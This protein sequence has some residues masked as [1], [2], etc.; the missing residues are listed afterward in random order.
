VGSAAE[1]VATI[2]QRLGP[3]ARVLSVRAEPRPGLG[4]WLRAPRFVVVA[5]LPALPRTPNRTESLVVPTSPTECPP[6]EPRLAVML[7]RAGFSD[8][9][10]GRLQALPGWRSATEQPLQQ[11]LVQMGREIHTTVGIRPPRP[12]PSRAAFFGPSGAGCTTALCKWLSR[13]VFT[14]STTGQVWKVEFD[15][16]NPAPALGV[17]CE[18]LSIPLE[19]YTPGSPVMDRGF[20]LV[21]LP[22]L[23]PPGT[24]AAAALASFFEREQITGRV[25]VLNAA[26]DAGS[27]RAACAR[28]REFGA[29]HLVLSHMDEVPHWGRLWEFLIEGELSPLFLSSGPALTGDI[30]T[31]VIGAVLRRTLPAS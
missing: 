21:D 14:R 19:H 24:P 27:L 1:A 31:E 3:T 9:L 30:E 4:R 5:E 8:R 28:G 18:A 2:Q 26:Y 22:G 16:P 15:R 7:R 13:E 17:F 29:T 20:L 23:P 6:A 10:L 11:A 12:L 25:L